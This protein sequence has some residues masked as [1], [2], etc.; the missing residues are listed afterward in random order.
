MEENRRAVL[1]AEVRPLAIHLRGVMHLPKHI[2]QLF[3]THFCRVKS[4]LYHFCVPGFVRAYVFVSWIRHLSAAVAHGGINYTGHA[5]KRRFHTP[6]A[7]RS[8]SRNLRHGY[9]SVDQAL[10]YTLRTQLRCANRFPRFRAGFT[11]VSAVPAWRPSGPSTSPAPAPYTDCSPK[12]LAR[13]LP[14]PRRF[15][16]SS[17]VQIQDGIDSAHNSRHRLSEA[18]PLPSDSPR[19]VRCLSFRC[20]P[21]PENR[22]PVPSAA[23]SAAP[24]DRR[25]CLPASAPSPEPRWPSWHTPRLYRVARLFHRNNRTA[26]ATCQDCWDP[27]REARWPLPASSAHSV[28]A[29]KPSLPRRAPDSRMANP[30]RFARIWSTGL[31][32]WVH[33]QPGM[34]R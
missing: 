29:D 17:R 23:P 6:E 31:R 30:E 21:G 1:R 15:S 24:T 26:A 10:R 11:T 27:W 32:A 25:S 33:P 9:L 20:S 14:W 34:R 16:L 28:P 4:H 19:P 18:A 22:A 2:Q 7:P 13:M 8:K 3:V 5:L 12:L